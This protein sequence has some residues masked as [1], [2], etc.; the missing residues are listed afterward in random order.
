MALASGCYAEAGVQ[1]TY[2]AYVEASA[3][4]ADLERATQTYYEGRTVY[5][6]NDRWYAQNRGR[7]VYYRHEPQPLLRQRMHAVRA[8][9][10]PQ[11][12][13]QNQF[14][15]RPRTLV[16]APEAMLVQ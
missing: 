12:V 2:P 14:S 5:Y 9:Q 15:T 1:P 11:H 8:P 3:P 4:P 16:D 6:V 10:A 7:W 13:V